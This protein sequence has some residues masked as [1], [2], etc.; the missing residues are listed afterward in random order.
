MSYQ[1]IKQ[2]EIIKGLKVWK[3]PKN[4]FMVAMLH[5]TADPAKDPDRQGKDWYEKEKMGT[6]KATWLKEYEI[7]FSTKSGKLIFGSDF[8]D[9]NQSIHFINSY[10]L[11]EPYELLISLDFGQRHPTVAL[12]GVWT[13]DNVLYIIDEYYKPAVPSVSSREMFEQFAYLIDPHNKL[14]GKTLSQKRDM[15]IATFTERVIDPSTVAKNRTKVKEGEEIPYSI[16]EDFWDNGWDFTPADNDVNAGITRIREYFQLDSNEKSHLYIFKDKCSRLCVELLNYRYK[17]LTEV[18]QKTRSA[19]EEPVKKD[20]DTVD[21][22]KYM[23][24]TRPKTP[25]LA[26]IPKTRIQRDIESLTRPR[27]IDSD[28]DNDGLLA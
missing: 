20:D 8:C 19:S 7:D 27:I 1:D 6:L 3:N 13:K 24:L 2:P 22:L 4:R 17:E 12:I 18:Q 21:A 26:P 28:W 11:P 5:Y 15:A 14:A 16:I 25:E 10:E 9:F 23:I